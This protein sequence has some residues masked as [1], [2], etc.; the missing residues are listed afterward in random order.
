MGDARPTIPELGMAAAGFAALL[1]T[2]GTEHPSG[3]LQSAVQLFAV[4]IPVTVAGAFVSVLRHRSQIAWV[5]NVLWVLRLTCIA[6]GDVLCG[7]G[8]YWVFRHVSA[9][10]AS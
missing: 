2:A 10:A 1:V 6:F 9:T 3:S 8:V 5:K 7:I 4:G